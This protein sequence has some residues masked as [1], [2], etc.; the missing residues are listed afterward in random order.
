MIRIFGKHKFYLKN[1]QVIESISKIDDLVFDK[2]GT[3][4]S[5]RQA[6]II[7]FGEKLEP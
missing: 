5:N 4:T 1:T 7:Y 6:T 3:I 2:T